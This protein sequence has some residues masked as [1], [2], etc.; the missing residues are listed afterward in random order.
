MMGVS[1]MFFVSVRGS[2]LP[3]TARSVEVSK[4]FATKTRVLLS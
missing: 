2:D 1:G 3:L 4:P